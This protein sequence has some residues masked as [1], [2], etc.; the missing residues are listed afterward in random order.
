MR[1]II[2]LNAVAWDATASCKYRQGP[3]V[4]RRM[5]VIPEEHL[6]PIA[7]TGSFVAAWF[8]NEAKQRE[9]PTPDQAKQARMVGN[10]SQC[11]GEDAGRA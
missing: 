5:N 10:G 8:A 6:Q 7:N 3:S 2:V 9:A 1:P 11:L 4:L